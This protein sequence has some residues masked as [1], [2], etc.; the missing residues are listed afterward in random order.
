MPFKFLSIL[1]STSRF[2]LLFSWL[3]FAL[4]FQLLISLLSP[5]HPLR[6]NIVRIIFKGTCR[7]LGLRIIVR[8]EPLCKIPTL[9]LS[10]HI[11]YLDILVLGATLKA[12][13]ISKEDVKKW[14]IFGLYAQLQGAIFIKRTKKTLLTQKSIILDRLQKGS[15]LILFPEGTTH[16]GIHV[17]PL[18][19]SLLE[20]IEHEVLFSRLKIQPLSLTY[21]RLCGISLSRKE[22]LQYSWFGDLALLPHVYDIVTQ[23]PLLIEIIAHTPLTA[24]KDL[25]RKQV[26]AYCWD[27]I[28]K[29]V[30]KTF[31]AP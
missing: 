17:L 23:G 27:S 24:Q 13:F 18:K 25:S 7:A 11:S 10:N 28:A 21:T 8:G 30:A 20:S 15:S 4:P 2:S 19:S 22:R 26:S 6:Q 12:S 29:G 16:T 14:P 31:Q 9:F 1:R 3:I 5:L